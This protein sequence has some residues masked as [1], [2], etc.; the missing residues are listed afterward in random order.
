MRIL[1]LEEQLTLSIDIAT[2]AHDGQVDKGGNK[3]ILHPLAVMNR[4]NEIK[5]KIA[6]VLH[7][8]VEDT[9]VTLQNLRERGICD[10]VVDAVDAL[11]K[12]VG[13]SYDQSLYRAYQNDIARAVKL[14]DMTENSDI[15][16]LKTITDKDIKRCLK[17]KRGIA[18]FTQESW[19]FDQGLQIFVRKG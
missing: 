11:T 5:E 6:A 13:D 2:N 4:V 15:T 14:A 1:T 7:D 19:Y 18:I 8:V 16:R 12:R 9:S 17:Y 3:Y 10:E